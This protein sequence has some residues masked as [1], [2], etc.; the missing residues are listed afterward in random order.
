MRVDAPNTV[1][2]LICIGVVFANAAIFRTRA[3]RYS[4]G[5]P[6]GLAEA[7]GIV[8][9]FV[10]F[11]GG[12]ILL[13]AAGDFLG[14]SGRL[15]LGARSDFVTPFDVVSLAVGVAML[16]R[17]TLWVFAQGGAE[18]LARHREMFNHFPKSVT[19]VKVFWG[20]ML[21]AILSGWLATLFGLS[22]R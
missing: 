2:W 5:N 14:L 13:Q 20:A 15:R 17:G 3:A 22:Q 21:V 18:V 1:F 12:L 4:A 19:G 11:A 9:A 7:R 16:G 8:N 6:Q 10:I